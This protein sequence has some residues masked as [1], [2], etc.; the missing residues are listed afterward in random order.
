MKLS[1]EGFNRLYKDTENC[2]C[3]EELG[4]YVFK[5]GRLYDYKFKATDFENCVTLTVEE[6]RI[7]LRLMDIASE[8]VTLLDD[9]YELLCSLDERIDEAILVTPKTK[10]MKYVITNESVLNA[11]RA[12]FV[13]EKSF[14]DAINNITVRGF[15]SGNDDSEV[16]GEVVVPIEHSVTGF[17]VVMPIKGKDLEQRCVIE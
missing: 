15:Y 14:E 2:Y 11:I 9:E 16:V 10:K 12:L 3:D 17:M 1:H 7:I 4:D 6:A 5:M 8:E 13:S